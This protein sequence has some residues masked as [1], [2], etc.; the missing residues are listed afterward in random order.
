MIRPEAR[1]WFAKCLAGGTVALLLA[2]GGCGEPERPEPRAE[3]PAPAAQ[4]ASANEPG[5]REL[6]ARVRARVVAG[7]ALN[8]AA[9]GLDV[10][11]LAH[12]LW[13][14]QPT[15]AA[16]VAANDHVNLTTIAADVGRD[17]ARTPEDRAR[18]A[19]SDALSLE[20]H[21][22]WLVA[23]NGEPDTYRT[24]VEGAGAALGKRLSAERA[25]LFP[26][27]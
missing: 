4:R 18:W 11:H 6:L 15:D 8:D 2:V 24:W 19:R 20:I 12:D 26:P 10:A 3:A 27:R 21:D 13:P 22:A 17:L 9:W 5:V 23:S 25:R 14:A 1:L 7:T 16:R